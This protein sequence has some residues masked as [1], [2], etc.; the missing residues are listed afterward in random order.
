MSSPNKPITTADA[1]N[2]TA[3][4]DLNLHP[5]DDLVPEEETPNKTKAGDAT[6]PPSNPDGDL[7]KTKAHDVTQAPEGSEP[8][9]AAS[10]SKASMLGDYRLIKK[11]GQG[12][13]GTV[14]KAIH[15]SLDREVAIKVLSKEL[16]G[17][18]AFVHRFIREAKLMAK[19]DHPNILRCFDA[20]SANGLHYLAIE[21]VEGGS[22][23]D[24]LKKLKKFSI[25]DSLRIILDCAA[26]LD[27]AHQQNLIHRD[28]K[29]DNI[30]LTKAGVVKVADL[31]LAKAIDDDLS[32]TKT[33]TG[34]G[35]PVY[36]APEQARDAKHVDQRADIYAL[37]VM[38]YV[39]ITGEIPFK[40]ETL[41]DLISAKEKGT[42]KRMRSMNS[43][44]PERLDLIVDKLLAKEPKLRYETCAALY[45]DLEGLG[46]AN[47]SLSFLGAG[48]SAT[49]S[50]PSAKTPRPA[51]AGKT[52]T[53]KQAGATTAV[54]P[55][56]KT[57]AG[58]YYLR[59]SHNGQTITKKLKSSEMMLL[60][61]SKRIDDS[62]TLSKSLKGL[63]RSV[64]TYPEFAGFFKEKVTEER[65]GN[66]K[67]AFAEKLGQIENEARWYWL[68]KGFR[69]FFAKT[70]GLVGLLLW[71][72][73]LAGVGA[74]GYFLY[75]KY[76]P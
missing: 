44:V 63:Y 24:Q 64:G 47:E 11:L 13:M 71:L 19:L 25:G 39:F 7:N 73:V 32:L 37:G 55:A 38:L 8:A 56:E 76:L 40:G 50:I 4:F 21:F 65:T 52:A 29:P 23:E 33:G 48:N 46:L 22:V 1:S 12:G 45:T 3:D 31:G 42:F 70:K 60:I 41:V 67:A 5:A 20:G 58:V 72:A 66:T 75:K 10:P 15:Q 61:K 62:A 51:S 16:C 30:L 26:A 59:Y 35:T 68:K 2:Q 14:Y 57:E 69:R 53:P 54:P 34:A 74:G 9:T 27:H 36:M 43:E 6:L 28:I 17:K 49:S 18:P